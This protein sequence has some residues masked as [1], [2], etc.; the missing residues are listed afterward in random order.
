MAAGQRDTRCISAAFDFLKTTDFCQRCAPSD[1]TS[2]LHLDTDPND[3]LTSDPVGVKKDE[4]CGLSQGYGGQR[5]SDFL[6][7]YIDRYASEKQLDGERDGE[8]DRGE[9]DGGE[10]DGGERDGER[11]EE[12]DSDVTGDTQGDTAGCVVLRKKS[13]NMDSCGMAT[14][15]NGG[16]PFGKENGDLPLG[17]EN[18]EGKDNRDVSSEKKH[19][20]G[21]PGKDSGGIKGLNSAS[22]RTGE[23]ER[24]RFQNVSDCLP[25]ET[26]A[27][28][29]GS[30]SDCVGGSNHVQTEGVDSGTTPDSLLGRKE[31]CK[32]ADIPQ[33]ECDSGSAR[34]SSSFSR[35]H[36][37]R[38][39]DVDNDNDDDDGVVMRPNR[40]SLHRRP[41]DTAVISS[42]FDFLPATDS[43]FLP[44]G[45]AT[46][47]HPRQTD[48]RM[49]MPSIDESGKPEGGRCGGEN[50][51]RRCDNIGDHKP[52]GDPMGGGGGGASNEA[53]G[54]SEDEGDSGKLRRRHLSK[55]ES[56]TEEEGSGD[57]SDEDAGVYAE[58]FRRS[59]WMRIDDDGELELAF[60]AVNQSRLSSASRSS[61]ASRS[62]TCSM[63][64]TDRGRTPSPKVSSDD[65]PQFP[66]SP[67]LYLYH[68]RS[69]STSTTLSERE[70]K[71]EYVTRRKCL[72]QRQNSSK[73]YHRF[74]AGVY[75]EEKNLRLEKGEGEQDFGIH[76]LDSQPAYITRVDPGSA[77][78]RG[79]V[80]EGQI[81]VK[82][83]GTNVLSSS[84]DDII[85]LIANS[86]SVIDVWV[87]LSDFQPSRDLDLAVMT[88]FMHKLGGPS[89]VIMRRWKRRYFVLRQDSCLYYYKQKQDTDPLGA[90]PL[91][92][93]T[94]SRHLDSG[95]HFCF[96]ADKYGARTY[97][98]MTDS[99]DVMTE[100]VG[101]LSEAAAR[102]KHRK[103]SFKESFVS[104]S[105]HNVGIPA[106]DIRRPECTGHLLKVGNRRKTWQRRYCVLKDAC[107]YYYKTMHSLSALGVAHLHGYRVD[108]FISIS[109]KHAFAVLPP[110]ECLRVF[111]FS[112]ENDTDRQ[113]W[114]QAMVRSIQRWIQIDNNC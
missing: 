90:I 69:D 83:N 40:K 26:D 22:D 73:E 112:A 106:L 110:V 79:G 34:Q 94:F 87:A 18:G 85:A 81:L 21:S 43:V 74:S 77:A 107:L 61:G 36:T 37:G 20:D 16:L 56:I 25:C 100:W 62:S 13:E 72:I 17:K 8:R 111:Q 76:I 3:P 59:N 50:S 93:Y 75:E 80:E 65:P 6:Q 82:V 42:V 2:H 49:S 9:R 88:G 58:S 38:D 57:S 10:R 68:K 15:Q 24:Q 71:K 48:A 60:P 92:G 91:V 28:I 45:G 64:T 113:R 98:F 5:G 39:D 114:V 103:E 46:L 52:N 105:S 55:Q 30:R 19:G 4:R 44:A 53:E 7:G 70:F 33:R 31:S 41:T 95:R 54:R 78:D 63:D 102:S 27:Q 86:G 66:S 89:S 67:R 29:S 101:A 1:H 35:L 97:Y 108:P 84:H 11:D 96:K 109:K 99:R 32:E 12:R 104:V 47:A 14:S 51:V 23:K